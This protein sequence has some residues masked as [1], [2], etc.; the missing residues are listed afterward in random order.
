MADISVL[1]QLAPVIRPTPSA[2]TVHRAL[3]LA[4]DRALVR[5][6]QANARIRAVAWK[7]IE[8]GG[9]FPQLEI[10][11]KTLTR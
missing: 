7:P 11:G 2:S 4:S 1:E 5:I 10:A 9:G 3:N 6:T 8:D